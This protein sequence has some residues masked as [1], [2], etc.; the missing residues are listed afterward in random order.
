MNGSPHPYYEMAGVSI[1]PTCRQGWETLA[2]LKR[3]QKIGE[4]RQQARIC[5]RESNINDAHLPLMEA[6]VENAN[7]ARLRPVRDRQV[8]PTH[9][10]VGV[11]LINAISTTEMLRKL[12]NGV[13]SVADV[14]ILK[15]DGI[16]RSKPTIQGVHRLMNLTGLVRKTGHDL[17][18]ISCRKCPTVARAQRSVEDLGPCQF[19]TRKQGRQ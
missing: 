15:I 13:H 10:V 19:P 6:N 2:R 9:R 18:P 7:P 5:S 11:P 4:D 16:N 1:I 17:A 3:E 8:I 12:K 14:H